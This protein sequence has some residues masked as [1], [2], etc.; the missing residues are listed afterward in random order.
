MGICDWSW[1]VGG[2]SEKVINILKINFHFASLNAAYL[3]LVGRK[4]IFWGRIWWKCGLNSLPI[5]FPSHAA[6]LIL[7]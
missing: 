7:I 5:V 6:H 2:R 1:M 4:K 3:L